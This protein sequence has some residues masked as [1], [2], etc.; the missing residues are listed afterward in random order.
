MLVDFYVGG[1]E[2]VV[3]YLFYVC[4]WYKVLFD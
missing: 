2:Y 1:V 4:F 3:L